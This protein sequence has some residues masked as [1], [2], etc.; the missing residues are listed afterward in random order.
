MVMLE[1][2]EAGTAGAVLRTNDAPQVSTTDGALQTDRAC[3]AL[4]VSAANAAKLWVCEAHD[5]RQL[6][7]SNSLMGD[8]R[9][10]K[11]LRITNDARQIRKTG[12]ELQ[13]SQSFNALQVG[14]TH[15][16][17]QVSHRFAAFQVCK[18]FNIWLAKHTVQFE[19]AI[20]MLHIRST[21]VSIDFMPLRLG[22]T[23]AC[24]QLCC[25]SC[26]CVNW[27]LT[28][29]TGQQTRTSFHWRVQQ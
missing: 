16:A 25:P 18:S 7:T 5:A 20:Y 6:S 10:A 11:Q 29:E 19:S 22:H 8:T 1:A 21:E 28:C 9:R 17:A 27:L 4:E 13:V 3:D 26:R 2:L 14:K 12:H 23:S 15:D 24:S